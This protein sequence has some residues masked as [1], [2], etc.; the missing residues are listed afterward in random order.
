MGTLRLPL[1]RRNQFTII[2]TS[3]IP[4]GYRGIGIGVLTS[5]TMLGAASG[6]FL[7]GGIAT[8]SLRSVFLV[9][10]GLYLCAALGA[11]LFL[12]KQRP[13]TCQL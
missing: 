11:F 10:S 12:R 13:T 7:A 5:A 9:N 1:W 6:P 8:V 2:L 3:L 4:E